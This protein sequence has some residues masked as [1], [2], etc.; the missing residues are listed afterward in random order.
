MNELTIVD[1]NILIDAAHQISS[2]PCFSIENEMAM[3]GEALQHVVDPGTSAA[4]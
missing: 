1:T 3:A 2:E 4:R